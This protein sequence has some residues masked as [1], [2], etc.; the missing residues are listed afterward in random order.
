MPSAPPTSS[1]AASRVPA[2]TTGAAA[3]TPADNALLAVDLLAGGSPLVACE[4][5]KPLFGRRPLRQ[6]TVAP[7]G[8]T[9][10]TAKHS[11]VSTVTWRASIEANDQQSLFSDY[12][13]PLFTDTFSSQESTIGSGSRIEFWPMVVTSPARSAPKTQVFRVTMTITWRSIDGRILATQTMYPTS[14]GARG[15]APASDGCAAWQPRRNAL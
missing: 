7:P 14:Y 9:V 3:G 8:V 11:G 1:P 5:D 4:Y 2:P 13:Q 10:D 12:W 6:M 15:S